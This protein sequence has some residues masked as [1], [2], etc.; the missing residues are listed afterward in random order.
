MSSI[1][2]KEAGAGPAVVF[3]H[4]FCD[5]HELWTDFIKPFTANCRVITPDL[6][7]FGRSERL[8][9]PFSIDQVGDALAKWLAD[10]QLGPV[11]LI[12]HSLG[13]Y[14]SL[15]LL[16]RHSQLLSGLVLF[17][18]TPREDKPERKAIRNKV[19]EFV[20]QNGVAP[21]VTTLVPG[22]FARPSD[23]MIDSTR[24]RMMGTTLEALIGYA[25][26]MRDRPDRTA[27]FVASEIPLLLIGGIKDSLISIEDLRDLSKMASNCEI[28]EAPEAAHMG[29]FEAKSQCQVA[30]SRFIA[31]VQENRLH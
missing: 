22:L 20:R 4:G 24:T 30:I 15:S 16:E 7:G 11:I 19:I 9:L 28:F 29:I 1:Y 10:R 23:P 31:R 26:A 13:G 18:S 2:F 25:E 14:V 6:P 8:P 21:Y 5:T 17:H 27:T 3:L 12:G